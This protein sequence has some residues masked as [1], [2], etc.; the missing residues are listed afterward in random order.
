MSSLD[1]DEVTT[2]ASQLV[3]A[4]KSEGL[5]EVIQQSF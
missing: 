3:T 5:C 1:V 2:C 4:G